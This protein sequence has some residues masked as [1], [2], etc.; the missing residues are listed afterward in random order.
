[1]KLL[2]NYIMQSLVRVATG[3]S[4]GQRKI[5]CL[6]VREFYFD[7]KKNWHLEEKSGKI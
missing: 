5:K 2:E 1:M 3:K 6:K 7:S 4:Y